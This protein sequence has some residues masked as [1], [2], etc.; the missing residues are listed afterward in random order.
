MSNSRKNLKNN[1][2]TGLEVA[3]IGMSGRFPGAGNLEQLWDNLKNSVESIT[4]FT[5]EELIEA[6]ISPQTLKQPN[7]VKARAVLENTENFDA[8]FFG[9]SPTEAEFMDPQARLFLETAWHALEDA[10]Y[11]S[12]NYDGLIGVY[13]GA[14][15]NLTHTVKAMYG[16][17]GGLDAMTALLLS[18]KDHLC[19]RISYVLNLRGPSYSFYTACSTSLVGIHLG[20][21][22]VL[23]GECDMALAGGVTINHP[24]TRGYTYQEDMFLS[25]DGHTRS[26]DANAGG[27]VDASGVGVVVLK[28]LEDALRDRDHI[29]A[30]V[31]GSGINNDGSQKI[32]YTAP[33]IKGQELLMK[34]VY[35]AAEVD[36]ESVTFMECHGSATFLGDPV[37]VEAMVRAF[38]KNKGDLCSLGAI[39]S[40]LGHCDCAAGVASF[41]KTVLSIHHRQLVPTLHFESPNPKIDFE[42]SPFYVNTELKDWVNDEYPLRAGVNS[43]GLGG[44]NAH[45]IVQEVTPDIAEQIEVSTPQREFFILPLSCKTPTALDTMTENMAR[46]LSKTNKKQHPGTTASKEHDGGADPFLGKNS[47]SDEDAH[48]LADAAYT[49]KYGRDEFSHRR[50]VVCSSSDEAIALLSD[51]ASAP[52]QP[53]T[54]AGKDRPLV[55]MFSGQGSEYVNMGRGLYE[56]EESFRRDIDDCF[57][58]LASLIGEDFKY[59]L[60]PQND[61]ELKDAQ[62]KIHQH[63]YTHPVKFIF[64]YAHSRLLM[65]WGLKPSALIGYSYGEYMVACTAGVFS[66]EDALKVLMKRGKLMEQASTGLMV[67]VGL[68]EAELE[69]MLKPG[70]YIGGVNTDRLCLVSGETEVID[71]FEAELNEKNIDVIRYRAAVGGHSPLV[72]PILPELA[73][74]LETITYNKPKIPYVS[75]LTGTWISDEL[76]RDPAY[77]TRQLRQPV[78]FADALNT[79]FQTPNCIFLEVG[80]GTSLTNFVRYYKESGQQPDIQY[81]TMV[82][83]HKD[84]VDDDYFLLNRVAQ[85]WTWGKTIDWDAFYGDE[86]RRRVSLPGYPFES[87]YYWNDWDPMK[88]V[89]QGSGLKYPGKRPDIADWLYVP[90]WKSSVQTLPSPAANDET[91]QKPWLIFMDA[92]N[93]GKALVEEI[94]R[95]GRHAIT[96]YPA[97]KFETTG[98]GNYN[99]NYREIDQYRDLFKQLKDSGNVPSSIIHLGCLSCKDPATSALE[100]N[101]SVQD[102]GFYS[103]IY[104]ARAIGREHIENDINI[105]IIA[106]DMQSAAGEPLD[107]PGKATVLGPVKNIP[108]EYPNLKCRAIDVKLPQ[109]GG[110]EEKLLTGQLYTE[111]LTPQTQ[112]QVIAFRGDQR[113]VQTFEPAPLKAPA[114]TPPC[115]RQEGVYLI[116]GGLGGIGLTL[117]ETFAREVNANVILTSRYGL[118]PRDQWDEYLEKKGTDND[119]KTAQRIRKVKEIESL[120]G[121]VMVAAVDAGDPIAMKQTV[122]E[123]RQRFGPINGIINCAFVPDGTVIDQRTH[124]I[125]EEI[126]APKVKAAFILDELFNAREQ[127]LDFFV[128]CS[129]LAGIFGPLGQVAYTAASAFQ[130]AFAHYRRT[131]TPR[132]THNV[133]IDW[134]GWAEV[135]GLLDSL[136]KFSQ[137][138]KI[139]EQAQTKNAMLPHEGVDAFNRIMNTNAPQVLVSTMDLSLLLAHLNTSSTSTNF[140]ENLA[141]KEIQ[142]PA[143]KRKRP[144]LK[145][146]YQAPRNPAETAIAQIWQDLFGIDTVG[147][148]DDFFE[149]GGDSLKAMTVSSKIHKDLKV[150][151]PIAVFFSSPTIQELAQ[152]IGGKDNAKQEREAIPIAPEKDY[153]P[154]APV[155]KS[156]YRIHLGNPG[157]SFYSVPMAF[158]LDG[159]VDLERLEN[160]FRTLIERNEI[161]RTSFH[162]VDGEF[163]V[164]V[165]PAGEIDFRF[166]YREAGEQEDIQDIIYDLTVP[167]DLEQA[168]VFRATIIKSSDGKN[169]LLMDTHQIIIDGT[170][171]GL[172]RAGFISLFMGRELP[173]VTVQYKD[174]AQWMDDRLRSGS[175]KE[176]EEYWRQQYQEPSPGLILPTDFPSPVERNYESTPVWFNIDRDYIQ[177]IRNFSQETGTTMF[178]VF[179]SALNVLLYNYSG[180]EDI[181]LGT[182]I[183]GRTHTDLEKMIGKFSNTVVLHTRPKPDMTY[184][185]FLEQIKEISIGAFKHQEYPSEDLFEQVNRGTRPDH[186]RPFY[187]MVFVYNNMTVEGA[188][189]GKI[190]ISGYAV[191]R[192][193]SVFDL[194]FQATEIGEYINVL[195]QYSNQLFKPETISRM[196]HR[197]MNA[198]E[199]ILTSPNIKLSEIDIRTEEERKD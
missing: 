91:T 184:R 14:K 27:L 100:W 36:T 15:F 185:E 78:R 156:M 106:N 66:V 48:F 166:Q 164:K 92:E 51:P 123:A 182:R 24:Q 110:E 119:D 10:G 152:Y 55:F 56:K 39:K 140:Q 49:M 175:F 108:Q 57:A 22:A 45:V 2:L 197:F 53:F 65:R 141:N 87:K 80:P 103:L 113:L 18:A 157:N 121:K 35:R 5:D 154:M 37:E 46:F 138:L 136:R 124:A 1:E 64:E 70:L 167:F 47:G 12:Y 69:P 193:K 155:Q 168:P 95:R 198:L 30:I 3:V 144:Q 192:T 178:M 32:G 130:D 147:I 143:Q 42:N 159:S 181:V 77:F 8:E 97:E 137:T 25:P 146:E 75:G 149:L 161:Y 102:N 132:T 142:K 38:H 40:N 54:D 176:S 179:F 96:V 63:Y 50:A 165:H 17:R 34:E 134:G 109:P 76:A 189:D 194:T 67:T 153:Y 86:K 16:P 52:I 9:F 84:P 148:N 93:R 105:E 59:I 171:A 31:K 11:I 191:K 187:N 163:M 111:F 19:T 89:V 115:L 83:H 23:S 118:P 13:A 58:Y 99:L 172:F 127:P 6:G 60:Y 150:K 41:I 196:R 74:A 107:H 190:S 101:D 151:I 33:S 122:D 81:A 133:T 145:T 114:G 26:F 61:Q 79:L 199:C 94:N 160:I 20:C 7:Y 71:A 177:R 90:S 88:A 180:Q 85:L 116:L 126:F 120:G 188:R 104:I 174:Y 170:S 28:T 72:E 73:Q 125:C 29:Y 21:Q 62:E 186:T 135:G 68:S 195:I 44:T 82:R 183:A 131:R 173:P 112:E 43:L 117:A 139:D 162:Q 158:Q 169:I 98:D 129:S 4:F 128:Q